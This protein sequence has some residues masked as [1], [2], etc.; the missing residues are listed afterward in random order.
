M[1]KIRVGI[2]GLRRGSYFIDEIIYNGGE[3]AAVCEKD[4]EYL[5]R[6]YDAAMYTAEKLGWSVINCAP[7]G[8]QKSKEEISQILIDLIDN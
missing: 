8:I 2:F 1:E 6:T 5:R 4:T 3:I 7:E